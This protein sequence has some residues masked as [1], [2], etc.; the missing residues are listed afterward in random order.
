MP[1]VA[2]RCRPLLLCFDF[3]TLVNGG[4]QVFIGLAASY[5]MLAQFMLPVLK[6]A[7]Q[8]SSNPAW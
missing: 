7:G 5:F 1:P 3:V 4:V 8:S 2:T 6:H